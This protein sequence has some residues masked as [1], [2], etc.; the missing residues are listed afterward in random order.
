MFIGIWK[1]QYEDCQ[2]ASNFDAH[3]LEK[4]IILLSC[5]IGPELIMPPFGKRS[6]YQTYTD[7]ELEFTPHR[8]RFGV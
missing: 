8:L 4:A 6:D 5:P 7:P 1:I 3:G 2:F